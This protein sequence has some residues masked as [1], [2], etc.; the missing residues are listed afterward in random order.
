MTRESQ[1]KIDALVLQKM[2]VQE[3]VQRLKYSVGTEESSASSTPHND[4]KYER[5]RLKY[6]RLTKVLIS[7]KAGIQHL[8]ERLEGVKLDEPPLVL[9]DD[10]MVDVLQQCEQRLRIVLEAI[11]QEEEALIRDMGEA[12]LQRNAGLPL[13]PPVVNNYRVKDIDGG[14]EA[15]SEEE[16]EEDLEEEVVDRES[17]KKQSGSIL[18]KAAKKTKKR[19]TKK[20]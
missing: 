2:A 4:R 6:E 20:S 18:D 5:Q 9:S 10:N 1:A 14:E 12:A 11:R 16:F 3:R 15:P 19:R 8:S 7:V 13:E 17:L